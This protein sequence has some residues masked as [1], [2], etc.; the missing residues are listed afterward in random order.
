[1]YILPFIYL[2]I[3]VF[4]FISLKG[5]CMAVLLLLLLLQSDSVV[6]NSCY[7]YTHKDVFLRS[8]RV[9]CVAIELGPFYLYEA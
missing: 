5:L 2:I 8:V 7:K 1:M 3:V 6:E 4:N 9:L